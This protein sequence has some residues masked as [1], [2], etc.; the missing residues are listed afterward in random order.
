LTEI[1]SGTDPFKPDF[2]KA[3]SW[4]RSKRFEVKFRP[5]RPQFG[6]TFMADALVF[7]TLVETKAQSSA[8]TW[9]KTPEAWLVVSLDI[10]R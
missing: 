9:R 10:F 8:R 5:G 3:S 1:A 6:M 2:A 7:R 4:R